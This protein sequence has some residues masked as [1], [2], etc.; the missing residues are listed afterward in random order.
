MCYVDYDAP[1]FFK[2]TRVRG[3]KDHRC[4]ECGGRIARGARHWAHRGLWDGEVATI[5]TCD[6]CV[7]LREA[8]TLHEEADG[9]RGAEATPPF[10]GLWEAAR[11][12]EIFCGL[13]DWTDLD[14][15]AFPP[16][17]A[18]PPPPP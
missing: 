3:R 9:C 7:S 12:L 10:G 6:D 2:E 1:A 11:E 8:V 17:A 5:R 18:E 13:D 14:E 4:C 15:F 16:A